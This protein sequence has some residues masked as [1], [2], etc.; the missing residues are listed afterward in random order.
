[1]LNLNYYVTIYTV[2]V[3][4]WYANICIKCAIG[5]PSIVQKTISFVI[6]A[7]SESSSVN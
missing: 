5:T 3:V 6:S 7:I 2:T 1:M 4:N